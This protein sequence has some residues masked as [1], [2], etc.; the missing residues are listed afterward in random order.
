MQVSAVSFQL[1]AESVFL[2][3]LAA[4]ADKMNERIGWWLVALGPSP[5]T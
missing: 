3:W 2:Y 5:A 1:V 4:A